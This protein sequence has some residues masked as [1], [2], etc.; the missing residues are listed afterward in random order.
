STFAG[1]RAAVCVSYG[2]S[3]ASDGGTALSWRPPAGAGAAALILAAGPFVSRRSLE[4]G[5][6]M[7]GPYVDPSARATATVPLSRFLRVHR[8]EPNHPDPRIAPPGELPGA[9]E[10]VPEPGE[11]LDRRRGI[12]LQERRRHPLG[13]RVLRRQVAQAL[14]VDR[15]HLEGEPARL[16]RQEP[17]GSPGPALLS[18]GRAEVRLVFHPPAPLRDGRPRLPNP[19]PIPHARQ[20]A[21]QER[22]LIVRRPWPAP[23]NTGSRRR[24]PDRP[25]RLVLVPRQNRPHHGGVEGDRPARDDLGRRLRPDRPRTRLRQGSRPLQ[26]GRKLTADAVFRRRVGFLHGQ[27]C[28]L[29]K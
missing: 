29:W 27:A 22:P 2:S 16:A 28:L 26:R 19:E 10:I 21:A 17:P 24:G 25:A 7:S 20:P 4:L 6:G 9:V 1:S 14:W 5:R 15:A 13:D 8:L 11:P 18:R 3:S 12:V 23:A